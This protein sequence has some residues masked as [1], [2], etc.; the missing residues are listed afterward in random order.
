MAIAYKHVQEQPPFP[1]A[2]GVSVPPPLEAIIMKLL[3]KSADN[4]YAN[5]EE[6]RGDLAL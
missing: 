2:F 4:R 6:L 1:S 3:S 5:A